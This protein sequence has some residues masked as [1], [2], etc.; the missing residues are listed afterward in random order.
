M[1]IKEIQQ[2]LDEGRIG[3]NFI[4]L[5][6]LN[7]LNEVFGTGFV[8]V[9]TYYRKDSYIDIIDYSDIDYLLD[10]SQ[11]EVQKDETFTSRFMP[12]VKFKKPTA[13]FLGDFT[14]KIFL[15]ALNDISNIWEM[16]FISHS[17]VYF[18][19]L[20]GSTFSDE[21]FENHNVKE[22]SIYEAIPELVPEFSY[23]DKATDSI[24]AK[25]LDNLDTEVQKNDSSTVHEFFYQNSI[26]LTLEKNYLHF[27]RDAELMSEEEYNKRLLRLVSTGLCSAISQ[28]SQNDF[29]K[30]TKKETLCNSCSKDKKCSFPR[31]NRVVKC[32]HF[33][34]KTND[35]LI[36]QM[37]FGES[38]KDDDFVKYNDD[39][40]RYDLV[41]PFAYEDLAKVLTF[42]AKKYSDNNW[43]KG[44]I[45]T[46]IAALE[47]HLS[48]VKKA[49]NT[50]NYDLF[51]DDDSGLQHGAA[52]MVNSM[53][54]H[55]FI[56]KLGGEKEC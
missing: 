17:D 13:D 37:I 46:Y 45:N 41:C 44:D 23:Y 9:N 31:T 47:R 33:E 39:K 42:G 7:K 43:I 1:N 10:N 19:S 2:E 55:H 18:T 54:I 15:N 22:V 12:N 27:M 8:I 26:D 21:K 56:N 48:E 52:L 34:E 29:Y 36:S 14:L 49:V 6:E 28:V 4:N 25:T 20:D 16:W 51:M 32:K 5:R 35:S 30:D 3:I 40:I 38:S 50:G 11:Q 53:F 24:K